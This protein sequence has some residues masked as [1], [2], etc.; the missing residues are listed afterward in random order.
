MN[1]KI[2]ENNISEAGEIHSESWK[3]SHKGFCTDEFI[4]R[5]TKEAQTEYIW[6]E[7]AKGKDFYMLVDHKPVGIG[8]EPNGMTVE[9]FV[10]KLRTCAEDMTETEKDAL[11]N[12]ILTLDEVAAL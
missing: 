2:T 12:W 9:Q 4:A 11:V 5:H 6:S 1:V 7:I 8:A 10:A 3:E